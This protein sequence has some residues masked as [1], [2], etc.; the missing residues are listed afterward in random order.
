MQEISLQ[1]FKKD[2]DSIREYIKYIKLI[3]NIGLK[4]RDSTENSLEKS[5]LEN[6]LKEFSEHLHFF[7][8]DKKLFEYKAIVISLYGVLEKYI[9]VW[10]QEHI[11]TLPSLIPNYDKLPEKIRKNH[12]DLSIKLIS[13]IREDRFSKYEHLKKE[14]V[15][16]RLSSCIDSPL[17]YKLNTDSF[18]PFSGNLKHVKIVEA[19]QPL[20]I[21]LVKKLKINNNFCNF[22]KK[23]YGGNIAN[24]GNELFVKIDDL[25]TRRNDIAH[26]VNID[27]ILN[28]TEFDDYIEFLENYGQAIFEI[29]IEKEIEY[30]ASHLCIKIQNIKGV[31]KKGSILCFE[32]ENNKIKVGDNIIIKITDDSFI[33]KEILGIQKD[34]EAFDELDITDKIDIGVNLDGGITQNQ[35]F[36]I[37]QK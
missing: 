1:N 35:I 21:D 10:I 28:I 23:N 12:F 13:L 17:E 2:I 31:Y 36:Y 11:D 30:E 32:I 33:K 5:P 29:L 3:N 6:S 4:N 19:F 9:G 22:L 8:K 25:V 24:K 7:S 27:D 34:K 14:D 16:T 20:D 37:K 26:G 15:L 18:S